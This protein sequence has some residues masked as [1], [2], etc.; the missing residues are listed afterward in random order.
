M[1]VA[2][3]TEVYL[4]VKLLKNTPLKDANI[5]AFDNKF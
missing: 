2:S 4:M 1:S 3:L 5:G